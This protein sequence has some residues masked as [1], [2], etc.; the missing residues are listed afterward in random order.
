MLPPCFNLKPYGCKPPGSS[1]QKRRPLSCV[2][3]SHK[4]FWFCGHLSSDCNIARCKAPFQ[5]V[6]VFCF[7]FCFCFFFFCILNGFEC[8]SV[9][10]RMFSKFIL[11]N[12]SIDRICSIVLGREL[13]REEC[14]LYKCEDPSLNPR[15]TC[16]VA[17]IAAC[18]CNPHLGE[19]EWKQTEPRAHWSVSQA[20]VVQWKI[21]NSKQ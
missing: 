16:K 3:L 9:L 15:G 4:G 13:S 5:E 1:Q 18:I 12:L 6:P 10:S 7:V 11:K 20:N 21:L 19:L 8:L 2:L 14:L 17:G